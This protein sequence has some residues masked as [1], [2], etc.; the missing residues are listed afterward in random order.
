MIQK[1]GMMGEVGTAFAVLA[2]YLLTIL[3]PLHHA[4]ATQLDFEKLGYETL[5]AGWIL[6]VSGSPEGNKDQNAVAK[7]KAAGIGKNDL[8]EPTPA[9][10]LVGPSASFQTE[11]AWFSPGLAPQFA[12]NPSAPSHA[13]PA[14]V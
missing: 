10:I 14:A 6:C 3:A 11:I 8:V 7:C 5:Q 13:P 2:L 4:R 1:R 9:T 12:T